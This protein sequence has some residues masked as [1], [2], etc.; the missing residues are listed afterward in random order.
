MGY[1]S[2]AKEE[3]PKTFLMMAYF[4]LVIALIY[5]LKPVRSALFLDQLGAQNLRY[6]YMS[7]GLFLILV[8]WA[9]VGLS[10]RIPKPAFF[11]VILGFF[12]S[13][14][15]LFWFLFRIQMNYRAAFFYIWVASFSITMT[16]QFWLL[17][18]DLF[19]SGEGKR[20]FGPMIS[21]GSAGGIVGGLF[22]QWAVRWVQTEDLL[23]I[24]AVM[25]GLCM[26]LS[27]EV[28]KKVGLTQPQVSATHTKETQPE[29]K[30]DW[31]SSYLIALISIIVFAK[32]ASTIVDN[33]FNRVV[34]L[35]I[36]TKQERTAFFGGFMAWTN[37]A[38]FIAQ[39][40]LTRLS[41]ERFGAR[42]SL[43]IL[44]IGLALFS[45]TS[46]IYPVLGFGLALKIFDG[47]MNYSIQ[48]AGKEMLFL[49]L[50]REVRYRVKPV[51]DM[52]GFRFAKTFAGMYIALV[53]PLLHLPDERLG[54][55][56]LL[57]IPFWILMVLTVPKG[58]IK[59]PVKS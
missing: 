45:F 1:F 56:V 26:I 17:A 21:A 50:L 46:L 58:L 24:A 41:L 54:L 19:S 57:L 52:L 59:Q 33:Q 42:R 43:L 31:K 27:V 13:N 40:F 29:I 28:W 3:R 25:V 38:S 22:T 49:P 34:E 16:T 39:L 36:A 44:P 8:V 53:A 35:S 5:I 12:A 18:N 11:L 48:Q 30:V 14:L 37:A 7:E 6:V 2:I 23:L 10:K 55:L 51:I 9:Y 15:V 32:M 20:L 47:S 4:F